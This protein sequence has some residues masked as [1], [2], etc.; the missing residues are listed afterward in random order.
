[1][2][3]VDVLR[4]MESG[5]KDGCSKR[6]QQQSQ[7]MDKKASYV[8]WKGQKRMTKGQPVID[9]GRLEDVVFAKHELKP[10]NP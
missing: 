2:R 8:Q 1:M 6:R 5:V 10:R 9:E 3:P 7:K 4:L